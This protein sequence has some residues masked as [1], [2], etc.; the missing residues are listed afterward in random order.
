MLGE[1]VQTETNDG[2][3]LDGFVASG[4]GRA[5]QA[6]IIL[7]GVNG[8]FYSSSILRGIATLLNRQ[9]HC[10]VL[11][12]TRGHDILSF[13]SGKVPFKLG[14]QIELIDSCVADLNAWFG[15]LRSRGQ[16]QIGLIGHSLGALK[17]VYWNS[18]AIEHG[19]VPSHVI[20]I[21]PPRL[22]TQ[23]LLHDPVKGKVFREHLQDAVELCAA[24][25]PDHVM[26]VRFPIPM[27]ICAS[28]YSDKYGSGERYDYMS[29]L[30]TLN[31]QVFWLFGETEVRSGSSNFLDADVRLLDHFRSN[32]GEET[33]RQQVQVVPG[34]DHSYRDRRDLLE[35]SIEGWLNSL[36]KK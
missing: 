16:I 29:L 20:A 12:N 3:V 8:N 22:N 14:S 15:F 18:R 36:Q 2:I 7:H 33:M 35:S 6:W 9:G 19:N 34:A 21:S 27:W 23:L 5:V 10:V 28:T 30:G 1:L 11:A 31:S 26:K 24:G 32:F 13:N 4:E 17:A 25:N